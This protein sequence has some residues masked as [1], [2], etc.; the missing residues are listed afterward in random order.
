MKTTAEIMNEIRVKKNKKKE[1]DRTESP[2]DKM[3]P[4]RVYSAYQITKGME[5]ILGN[6]VVLSAYPS[7]DHNPLKRICK[8]A[9]G[10]LFRGALSPFCER[11]TETNYNEKKAMVAMAELIQEQQM[12]LDEL[13]EQIRRLEEKRG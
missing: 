9:A 11:I 13:Y 8:R 1:L 6:T 3:Q 10:M 5:E 12:Q 7:R 2:E 4:D